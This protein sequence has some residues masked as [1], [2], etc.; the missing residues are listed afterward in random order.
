MQLHHGAY[1]GERREKSFA[2][3]VFG[4]A[5]RS[6]IATSSSQ[7]SGDSWKRGEQA[8]GALTPSGD[9]ELRRRLAVAFGGAIEE[10]PVPVRDAKVGALAFGA[11][12]FIVGASHETNVDALSVLGQLAVLTDTH[13]LGHSRT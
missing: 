10:L 13:E 5:S 1:S 7:A 8:L 2:S 9:Q 3:I 6:K 4:L 12:G 11:R